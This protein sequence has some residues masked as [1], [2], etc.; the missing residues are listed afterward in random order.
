MIRIQARIKV[1]QLS[2]KAI[3]FDLDGTLIDVNLKK[4]IPSYLKLLAE[5]ISHLIPPNKVITKILKVS[6]EINNN[7]GKVTNQEIFFEK[8]FPIDGFD[9]DKIQPLFDDFYKTKFSELRQY[10]RKKPEAR[11]LMKAAFAKGYKVVIATTPVLPLSAIQQRLDW[12]E[13]GD[14][15]YDLITTIENSRANKPNP[16]YYKQIVD[17][18]GISPE[19]CLMVGDEDKDM[20]AKTIGCQTFLVYSVNTDVNL[21]TPKPNY[22]GTLKDLIKIL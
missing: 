7:N 2:N 19:D 15:E 17:Y 4:F 1:K 8:F 12:A 3:L 6:E 14:F 10:T 16:V 20:V 18:L 22:T 9:K 5:S 21:K 13:V 11:F